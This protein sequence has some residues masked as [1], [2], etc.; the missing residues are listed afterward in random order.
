MRCKKN[1]LL[2]SIFVAFTC[3]AGAQTFS[4]EDLERLI[5]NH[6]MLKNYDAKTRRFK[7]TPSEI[8]P[9]E[10]VMEQI[11][12]LRAE[13]EELEKAREKLVKQTIENNEAEEHNLWTRLKDLSNKIQ[14][15]SSQLPELQELE[16][17]GGVPPVSR[18]IPIAREILLDVRKEFSD[19]DIV[20]N[21]LPVFYQAPPQF[22][23]N[24][25]LQFFQQPERLEFLIEYRKS[26]P[27]I[28][29]L[30][31]GINQPVLINKGGR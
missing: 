13:I 24:P 2:L 28:S 8:V 15:K 1:L 17:T 12:R 25:L 16:A 31:S 22:H 3:F 20:L 21:R 7:N 14:T 6:S 30:F 27:S 26:V 9:V 19:A 29:L 4:V 18:V 10:Q 5:N 11:D 23:G